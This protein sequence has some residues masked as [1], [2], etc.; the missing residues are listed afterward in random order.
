MASRKLNVLLYAF[1]GEAETSRV[2]HQRSGSNRCRVFA[3]RMFE[4]AADMHIE[5]KTFLTIFTRKRNKIKYR[6]EHSQ[7]IIS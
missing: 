3:F 7:K 2:V 4:L 6:I 5:L 1:T